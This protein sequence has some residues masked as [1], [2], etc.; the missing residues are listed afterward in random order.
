MSDYSPDTEVRKLSKAPQ[1]FGAL[2]SMGSYSVTQVLVVHLK[3]F[4]VGQSFSWSSLLVN[5]D[6]TLFILPLRLPG[7][8]G[9]LCM[10]LMHQAPLPLLSKHQSKGSSCLGNLLNSS[11][12]LLQHGRSTCSL[13]SPGFELLAVSS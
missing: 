9:S 5:K 8:W 12:M 11:P 2:F 13:P 1:G 7:E 6:K 10:G 4:P 3:G